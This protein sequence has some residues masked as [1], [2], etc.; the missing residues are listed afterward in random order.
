MGN[1]ELTVVDSGEFVGYL[2]YIC[3]RM[4]VNGSN[5]AKTK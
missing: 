3:R 5:G 2:L 4:L 1:E